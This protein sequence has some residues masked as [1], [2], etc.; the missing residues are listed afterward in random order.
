MAV[1]VSDFS[2]HIGID[3][4]DRKYGYCIQGSKQQYRDFG[5]LR[6]SPDKINEW[7]QALH[8]RFGGQLSKIS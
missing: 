1:Q 5:V 3:W 6:H 8:Q 2:T 4:A 7:V